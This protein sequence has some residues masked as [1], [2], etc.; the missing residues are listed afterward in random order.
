MDECK[1][2]INDVSRADLSSIFP[3]TGL[4]VKNIKLVLAADVKIQRGKP[5]FCVLGCI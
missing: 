3:S 5:W 4:N 2:N 1:V